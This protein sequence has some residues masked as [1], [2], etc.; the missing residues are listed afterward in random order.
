MRQSSDS[1]IGTFS[2]ECMLLSELPASSSDYFSCLPS[3]WWHSTSSIWSTTFQGDA[4]KHHDDQ[5]LTKNKY[6]FFHFMF[7]RFWIN[8]F[9]SNIKGPTIVYLNVS[10][11]QSNNFRVNHITENE[12]NHKSSDKHLQTFLSFVL[13]PHQPQP[14]LLPVLLFSSLYSRGETLIKLKMFEEKYLPS[15]LV[16]STQNVLSKLGLTFFIYI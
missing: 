5:I 12:C 3:C 13:L 15:F 10:M 14:F 1:E 11:R 7:G 2:A 9:A 16:P 8:I 6:F 4:L